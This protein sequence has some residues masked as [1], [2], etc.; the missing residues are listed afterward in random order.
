MMVGGAMLSAMWAGGAAVNAQQQPG[1]T[2]SSL[3]DYRSAKTKLSFFNS[4]WPSVFEKLA[5][6]TGSTLVMH[7]TPH[8]RL[9]RNDS[10]EYTRHEAVQIL[11]RELEPQGFR[12]LEKEHFLIIIE[13]HA[14]RTKYRRP[15]MPS[16]HGWMPEQTREQVA[17][18]PFRKPQ[19][20]VHKITQPRVRPVEYRAA[21][22][23]IAQV[24]NEAPRSPVTQAVVGPNSAPVMLQPRNSAR[25]ISRA[26]Y[27]A[28]RSRAQLV[29]NGPNAL[30]AFQVKPGAQSKGKA[31]FSVGIDLS[32]NQLAVQAPAKYVQKVVGLIQYLDDIKSDP[33]Q[34]FQLIADRSREMEIAR[35]LNPHLI[36]IADTRAKQGGGQ[37][38]AML[39]ARQPEVVQTQPMGNQP[40][41]NQP[42]GDQP[43][44]N[45]GE[46]DTEIPGLIGQIRGPVTIQSLPDLDL[47]I[48]DGAKRDVDAVTRIIREIEKRSKGTTP[49]INMVTVKHVNS[50]ALSV[51]LDSVYDRLAELRNRTEQNPPERIAFIPVVKPNAILVLAS[52]IDLKS[53]NELIAKLDQPADPQSEVEVFALQN[54]IATQV[55]A[56]L[57]TLFTQQAQT[58]GQD[59]V[60]LSGLSE[61]IRVVADTRTNSLIVQ[62]QPNDLA[63]VGKII[64][65][66]DLVE[67]GSVNK[68]KIFRL[69]NAVADEL[70]QVLNN[71]IQSVLNPTSITT[72]TG[73]Q[74][75]AQQGQNQQLREVRS[76][77]LEFLAGKSKTRS[78]IVADIRVTADLRSNAVIVTAPDASMQLMEMLIRQLDQPTSTV[79]E[80][81]V[82][83]LAN[84]DAATTAPLL[85]NLFTSDDENQLGVQLQGADG[86][87]SGLI[88]V[89]FSVDSRTNSIVAIGGG[90]ALR[91]VEAILFRLDEADIRERQ[92]TV[93]RLANTPADLIANAINQYLQAQRNLVQIDP[94][95]ISNTTLLEQEII[96]VPE[97]VSNSIIV[98]ATPRYYEEIQRIIAELDRPPAQVIIQA[99]LVEVTL[100]NTDEF[101]I[102]LGFQDNVLFDRSTTLAEDLLTIAQTN[103][104]PNGV[105]TTTQQI[106]SQATTPGFLFNNQPLGQNIAANPSQIGTQGLSNFSLGRVNGDLGFG[107]LVLSAS[108]SGVSALLRALA[109]RRQVHILS[110]PQIRTVDNQL[111]QIQV[112]QQ[113]PII[114]GFN[115]NAT[116][117]VA[118]PL[119]VQDQAGII[120]TVT[121]RVNPDET[122]VMEVVAEKSSFRTGADQ[123]VIL[124]T[125]PVT[126]NSITSPIKDITTAR[127]TVA[128]P[129]S[130]TIVLGGMITKSDDTI[131]RKVPWLGDIPIL[132]SGFRYDSSFTRRTELL[133]FLTPRVIRTDADS[134][135]V[136]QIEAE[137]MHY[138][139]QE[140]EAIHGPLFAIPA[141]GN[142]FCPLPGMEL[143]PYSDQPYGMGQPSM[144]DG[145]SVPY[146]GQPGMD[147]NGQP[148]PVPAPAPMNGRGTPRP[149]QPPREPAMPPQSGETQIPTT[150]MPVSGESV[151]MYEAHQ[152]NERQARTPHFLRGVSS[153]FG[154]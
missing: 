131:E 27:S 23:R 1:N 120:L 14:A 126:G 153:I 148:A 44:A 149:P 106:I 47:M 54:A 64:Q 69:K 7:S 22:T 145:G 87:S 56:N 123:G 81:K 71:A 143:G 101:G 116:T 35:Q 34:T 63:T 132:G 150:V 125:D 93:I 37:P 38:F 68:I 11:N 97:T 57:D 58:Q 90:D 24:S 41:G 48:I 99:M 16:G 100:D 151:R 110:R 80:I 85:E 129:N 104:S 74:N 19:R 139:E 29:D 78:G 9:S 105:Q 65:K 25:E 103:T 79:A 43:A 52:D 10:K 140:A 61:R 31:S 94:E 70:A 67:S 146:D 108:S 95:L 28:L 154:G 141:H 96:A 73:Q 142:D 130:Q 30:P 84:A 39:Q 20:S 32:A 36:R 114:N 40:M 128:V 2:W 6:R 107:G 98:S 60:N 51:L 21:D 50:I 89:R 115:T 83:T 111:A 147:A 49:N 138:I 76:V 59:A 102:E 45:G 109:S 13:Q 136:K 4:T 122:I 121:P 133:I 55:A 33:N 119:V 112:G 26:L 18:K 144:R 8:G 113:V 86:A 124:F 91:V 42:M 5:E 152:K 137:R 17:Q 75:F 15:V 135:L 134:E 117:G 12:I 62:A 66:I 77:V 82:F 118:N 72:G 88:P 46:Q 53:I 127:T 3:A 92:T